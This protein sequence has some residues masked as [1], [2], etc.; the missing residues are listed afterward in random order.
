[1]LH[2][3]Q[4]HS[5]AVRLDD[6]DELAKHKGQDSD[7]FQWLAHQALQGIGDAQVTIVTVF[8]F[9]LGEEVRSV[10]YLCLFSIL[11]NC[12]RALFLW[13]ERHSERFG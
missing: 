10:R 11:G 1:M 3:P 4:T 2:I 12:W 13:Q 5:E 8:S 7:I 6:Y 9:P